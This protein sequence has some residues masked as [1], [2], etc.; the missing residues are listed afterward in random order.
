M[1]LDALGNIGDFLGGIG[2]VVT[3]VYLAAQIRQNTKQLRANAESLRT[4]ALDET[5][6]SINHWRE[7]IIHRKDVADL[8]VR[9]L[10]SGQELDATDQVRFD[11]LLGE[12]IYAWQATFRRAVHAGD[13]EHWETAYYWVQATLARPRTREFWERTKST[14]FSDFAK[15]IDRMLLSE[16]PAA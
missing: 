4:A 3:L 7:G 9:G 11:I 6:R 10:S 2:V 8:W 12:L 16:P 13:K 1:D 5:Q 14:Y 15:E